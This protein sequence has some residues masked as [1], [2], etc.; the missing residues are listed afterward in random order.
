M[1][2]EPYLALIPQS[3]SDQLLRGWGFDLLKEYFSIVQQLPLTNSPVVELAT[4]TG[5]MCAALSCIFP[6]IIS[7]DISMDDLPRVYQRIPEQFLEHV[8]FVQ[9]DM[10]VLPFPSKSIST[11][12]CLNTM[13]EVSHPD[14]CLHEMIRVMNSNGTLVIG[15]FNQTGFDSMQKIHEIVYHNDHKEGSISTD[16]IV[17]VLTDSFQTV[18]SVTTPLNITYFASGKQ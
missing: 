10:E 18:R 9:L 16:E 2:T 11:L 15:D 5:R 17:R 8:N 12:V 14:V 7:G 6:K 4:G 3:Q 1:I 13:H